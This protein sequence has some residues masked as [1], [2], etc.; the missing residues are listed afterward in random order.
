MMSGKPDE[1]T[2]NLNNLAASIDA[3]VGS[4]KRLENNLESLHSKFDKI[5]RRLDELENKNKELSSQVN[6]NTKNIA[7]LQLVSNTVEDSVNFISKQ[8][9]D[10]NPIARR[11]V[12]DLAQLS[13]QLKTVSEEN[14]RLKS[15]IALCRHDIEVERIQRNTDAQYQRTS[16]NIKLCG[17]PTQPGED[18]R[19]PTDPSNA[20][21]LEL[22]NRVCTAAGITFEEG[23]IDVCHRLGSKPR[24][25]I[26]IRFTS[27]RNRYK[28]YGQRAKLEN[29]STTDIDY[30]NLPKPSKSP[31]N[32][33]RK[34]WSLRSQSAQDPPQRDEY[35]EQ[36]QANSIYMQEHLTQHTKKL[37]HQTRETLKDMNFA[38]GGYIKDGEV[39]VKKTEKDVPTTIRSPADL[40]KLL[41][42]EQVTPVGDQQEGTSG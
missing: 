35:G 26:I 4:N 38:Y 42:P 28:F 39:R 14:V 21:T 11:N 3:L 15:K 40:E 27:K 5:D 24:S 9:D 41:N 23:D 8:Y 1:S 25:P 18:E 6:V 34:S 36:E 2:P 31:R 10:L 29:V 37:L 32:E 17:L 30:N 19:S 7:D 33:G 12:N 22:I 16:I 20:V 13:L